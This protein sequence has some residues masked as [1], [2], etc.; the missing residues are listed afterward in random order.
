MTTNEK[1]EMVTSVSQV[2]V[3]QKVT[4]AFDVGSFVAEVDEIKSM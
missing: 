3:G 4:V 2:C 1:N